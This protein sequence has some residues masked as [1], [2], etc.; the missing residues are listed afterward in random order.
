MN[1]ARQRFWNTVW[2]PPAPLKTLLFLAATIFYA[3]SGFMYFE[4]G[5]K[6]EMEWVDALW[7]SLVTM[8]TVGFGDYFPASVAGRVFVGIPTMLVG[9]GLLGLAL[10]QIAAFFVRAD[11]LNRKGLSVAK[12]TGH[13]LLCNAP[14]T[15]RLLRILREIRSQPE[16]DS[17]PIVLVDERRDQLS[18]QLVAEGLQFVRGHPARKETL[19]RARIAGAER[20]ILLARDPADA[21]SDDLTVA[22]CLSVTHMRPDLHVVAECVEP[23]NREIL[24]RAGCQSIVCVMDL[25]PSI[26][27]QELHGPGLVDTLH[28]LTFWHEDL[29]NLYVV[30]IDIGGTADRSVEDLRAWAHAHEVTVL[31]LRSATRVVINPQ[32]TTAVQQGD[33]AVIIAR[34]RPN[35]IAL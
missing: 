32:V 12:T 9:M 7:W 24:E 18:E 16:L 25:G 17:T 2:R 34:S 33:A 11:I 23:G 26:L 15:P 4:R 31:G 20:A 6:P 13:I 8:T 29:N 22:T 30:P 1:V 10:S 28:E 35:R 19:D 5:D 14:S 21:A 27:A 3:T